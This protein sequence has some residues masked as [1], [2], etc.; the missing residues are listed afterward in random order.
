MSD[1][2]L[3]QVA[4][5]V[6]LRQQFTYL[7]PQALQHPKISVG[8]QVLVPFGS[9]QVI[10]VIIGLQPDENIAFDLKK[11]KS[12][13]SR[14][15]PEHAIPNDLIKLLTISAH[16]YQHPIGEVFQH[17]LPV[18]LRQISPSM[19]EKERV[20][21]S[22]TN[23]VSLLLAQLTKKRAMK[24]AALLLLIAKHQN[25]TWPELRTLGYSKQQLTAL[26]EKQFIHAVEQE[27]TKFNWQENS[28]NNSDKLSLSTEQAVAVAAIS[29]HKTKFQCHL[30]HGITGSGKTEV[31]L[32][33]MEPILAENMQVLV[34][35]PEIGLTPQM[36]ARFEQRF[37]V[38]V[39]LHHSGL[40][41]KE[42]F[43]TWQHAKQGNAA[44]IIGTRSA[45]FTP[46]NQLGM[47]IVD[48]EHDPSFKQQDSFRYHGRDLA[49]IRAR[50]QNIPIVLGSA[51]PSFESLANANLK[52]YCYHQLTKRPGNS[53]QATLKLIDVNGQ[54]MASGLTPATVQAISQTIAK[55][56]QVLVFINRRGFSP[57]INCKE[58]HWVA[59]CQRCNR[60][61]TLHKSQGLL[62]CHHCN[63]QKRIPKQCPD[64]GSIRI[65]PVGQGTEQVEQ[66]L[67]ER[68]SDHSVVRIDRDS[69]RRKGEL[70][71]RL[72]QVATKQHHILIGTQMLAKGHH[73]PD[74]TLVVMLDIDGA[75]FSIDYR[76]A[77]HMAQLLE[78]V[79]GRAGRASKPGTVYI[80]TQYPQHPLLHQ[81]VHQGYAEFANTGLQERKWAKL[82]PY[83]FQALIRAEAN[84]PYLP[85]QFLRQI[86]QLSLACNLAGPMPAAMEKKAGKY[87]YHLLVQA[88]SRKRLHQSLQ[89]ILSEIDSI[90]SHSKV[91]WSIDVDPIDLSW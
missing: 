13:V 55:D 53:V 68:F 18:L 70:S 81:L 21:R 5:P 64:C 41:D 20:W 49:I 80:Q 77:E 89:M 75:L 60:P 67:T 76:A 63:S 73:F 10:G 59:D 82:P 6:P 3:V 88:D 74:V 26:E 32:Q 42:R 47:I 11:L 51:T 50:Q 83:S 12:I 28:I 69:T 58:C 7:V 25:I 27:L 9:R 52:K 16:Y 30:L 38:P 36:L 87:R 15:N 48:E 39:V 84:T 43:A 61:Y 79:A 29:Q 65:N 54:S 40:N 8:E 24:Q 31:Y 1:C 62:I 85:E 72:E 45:V 46:C 78:Q 14:V 17:A 44:I 71:K 4:I 91:R 23:D 90:E 19:P 22:S 35:V 86:S 66:W 37:N 56:E 33:A 57:A 2:F 34:L